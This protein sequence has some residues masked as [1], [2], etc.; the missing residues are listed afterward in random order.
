MRACVRER[1]RAAV[2]VAHCSA[3]PRR[4]LAG[5]CPLGGPQA[6]AEIQMMAQQE[7]SRRMLKVCLE[8]C[9]ALDS[10][11]TDK[12]R[13]CLDGCTGAFMATFAVAS[14]TVSSVV[15]KQSTSE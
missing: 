8:R 7:V 14:E 1:V 4:Q 9:V 5:V 15:K 13:R 2:V 12:Q 6:Q 10:R 11:L 3:R